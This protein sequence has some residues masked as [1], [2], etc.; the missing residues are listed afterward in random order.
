MKFPGQ[1]LEAPS[2]DHILSL[3]EHMK[4]VFTGRNAEFKVLRDAF[5]G[6]F[7][8]TTGAGINGSEGR[9]E[10]TY[11]ICN[12]TVR[13]YLDS[14]SAPPRIEAQPE[15]FDLEDLELADKKT[16]FIEH[17]FNEEKLP[18]KLMH[19]AFYQALLDKAIIHIRPAPHLKHGFRLVVIAPEHYYPIVTGD[20]YAHPE[21]VII[22]FNTYDAMSTDR[23]EGF[24]PNKVPQKETV[25]YWDKTW[26]KRIENGVT[27]VEIKHDFGFIPV[28][29]VHNLPLPNQHRGQGDIDHV[30]GL[31]DYL[32][33]LFSDLG[34]MI[35]YAANPI[36]IIRG[37]KAGGANLPF[38][39]R[40]VWELERD[41][42]ASFLQWQGAPPSVEAQMLRTLQAVEDVTGVS[43]PAFGRDIPSGTSDRAI[44]SI[45]AGFNTRLGTKQ[46]LLAMALQEMSNGLLAMAAKLYPKRAYAI[47]G[48]SMKSDKNL[49]KKIVY[50]VK[51]EE[52]G[53]FNRTRITFLPGDPSTLYF[54]ET[55]KMGKGLQS[56]FTTMKNL[57]IQYPWEELERMR[58]EGEEALITQNNAAV[59]NKGEFVSPGQQAEADEA[60][61]P[62]LEGMM[63]QLR[64]MQE[65]QGQRQKEMAERLAAKRQQTE[66]MT[67]VEGAGVPSPDQPPTDLA[68]LSTL[69]EPVLSADDVMQAAKRAMLS[70]TAKLVANTDP[71]GKPAN[72]RIVLS[73]MADEQAL[74]EQLG[75]AGAGVVFVPGG[76][77]KMAQDPQGSIELQGLKKK[78]DLRTV[79]N[80][81]ITAV[82]MGVERNNR[83]GLIFKVGVL[84]DRG[85]LVSL[86]NTNPQRN[87][88]AEQGEMIR[89]KVSAVNRRVDNGTTKW[90]VATPTVAPAKIA[91]TKP[92]SF[93]D[94][95]RIWENGK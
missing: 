2:I 84:N 35:D 9:P 3:R 72:P 83:S 49:G 19:I 58:L 94:I 61:A 85:D 40:A 55:D 54:Q 42:Q 32:N 67:P 80:A 23:R 59:A 73:N 26:M 74:R 71:N 30:I 63:Q 51:P 46:Q 90:S 64:G 81:Y 25:E 1:E 4:S 5:T 87:V 79:E 43:S 95:E 38:A 86:C 82:V 92:S 13:R 50:E 57:G 36:A 12:A 18:L 41:A 69:E 28:W 88:S 24:D 77:D 22:T 33:R 29:E 91:P 44:R 89:I 34:A 56:K 14:M 21:G 70:G 17:F 62:Q 68:P 75:A 76:S 60:A 11:N 45:L 7:Q 47:V 10:I 66:T 37:S 65:T 93:A 8:G 15:G 53:E 20:D 16:K 6:R 27:K 52:F 78:S 39:P 31:N 48:E